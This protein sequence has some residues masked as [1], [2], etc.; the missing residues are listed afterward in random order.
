ML[1]SI[2]IATLLWNNLLNSF[3]IMLLVTLLWLGGVGFLDDYMKNFMKK[4]DGLRP[5]YKLLGQTSLAIIICCAIYFS[6][7]NVTT[8]ET[9]K[10]VETEEVSEMMI[11]LE[12]TEND[13]IDVG[14]IKSS[15]QSVLVETKTKRQS[16]KTLINV[17]FLKQSL[18][19]GLQLGLLFIPFV[20]FMIVG[21]SN[22]VNLT[23]GLDGLAAGL[24]AFT[25]FG[26][27]VM[28]YLKGNIIY[29]R[30]LGL[31]IIPEAGEL[32][33]FTASMIGTTLGFL[34]YNVKPA[35][36]F[37]G[38]TGSLTMGGLLAVIAI[39]LQEQLLFAIF[40]GIFVVEA[41]S[42]MTQRYYFKYTR[43]RFG[44]GVRF[45]KKAPLHHHYE[46]LGLAEN[47]IVVR[48]WIIGILLVA[49]GLATLKLR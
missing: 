15:T 32:T 2:L 13:L 25:T 19:P 3:I 8:Y 24:I 5:K 22:A 18:F 29:S 23:D 34:W 31:N 21:T 43:W 38:D 35:Q 30:Y 12:D 6:P 37:M 40:G 11:D 27:G 17:P 20:I 26:L 47:K 7:D 49:I 44:E 10:T 39:F 28:A 46:M 45:F 33:I 9:Y 36:I 41:L 48:F 14:T 16:Q 4:K 42:S 1:S